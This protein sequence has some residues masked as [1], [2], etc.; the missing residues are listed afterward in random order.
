M[1]D[2]ID[3][4]PLDSSTPS[5]QE[6]GHLSVQEQLLQRNISDCEQLLQNSSEPIIII[7]PFGRILFYNKTAEHLWG[8]S[9]EEAIGSSITAFIQSD[10]EDKQKGFVAN[11]L[12]AVP[13]QTE[14]KEAEAVLKNG[15]Y[16]PM[17]I[18]MIE[19]QQDGKLVLAIFAKNI[20][21]EKQ[22]LHEKEEY[23][24]ELKQNLEQLEEVH[25]NYQSKIGD[26]QGQVNAINKSH[27]VITFDLNGYIESAN[28]IFLDLMEYKA[29]EIIGKHHRLFVTSEERES[30]A[31]QRFWEN[32]K[33]GQQQSGEFQRIT[34]SGKTVWIHGSYNPIFDAE[35]KPQK[36]VKYTQDISIIKTL[37]QHSQ[38]QL[39]EIR[40]T[41]EELRQNME[42]LSSMQEQLKARDIE[43]TGQLHAIDNSFACVEFDP[44]GYLLK[45]NTMFLDMFGYAIAEVQHKHHRTFVDS[46][47]AQTDDYKRFW[48]D[49]KEGRHKSGTF[50]RV[51]K[52]GQEVWISGSYTPVFNDKNEV[53]K[54]IKI[55]INVTQDKQRNNDFQSQL[56]AI[57]RTNVVVEFDLNGV[58]KKINPVFSELVGYLPYEIEGKHHSLLVDEQERYSDEYKQFWFNLRKGQP[59]T[60]E[61]KRIGKNGNVVW[62]NA[63]YTPI[64]DLNGTPYKI[65]KYGKDISAVKLLEQQN[66][67]Q[68]EELRATEEELR[69]NMEE[70]S[71]VQEQLKVRDIEMTGQMNAIDNSFAFIEF[72]IQ[73][74]ILHANSLFLDV[75]GYT[76][77]E[78][79]NRHHKV[80][81]DSVY[82]RSDEYQQFWA[83]L[84][85]AKHISGNFKRVN[86]K[87][88][89]IWVSGSYTPVMNDRGEVAKVIKIAIDITKERQQNND[90]QNQLSAINKSN[91]VV[92]FDLKGNVIS[93]NPI[94]TETFHY[95]AEAIIGKH[96]SLLVTERERYSEDYQQFW[97]KLRKGE[98]VTG[99]FERL[100]SE[101]KSVWLH[102]SY[103]P[104]L[105][106]NGMPYKIV[107][108]A[109]DISKQKH[110]EREV[111]EQ[112]EITRAGEEELRQNMEELQ[113]TQENLRQSLEEMFAVQEQLTSSQQEANA[114][115]KR[116]E[117][118]LEGCA[119]AVVTSNHL[120]DIEF[121]NKA[122][123]KLWGYTKEEM[124]GKNVRLLMP[125]EHAHNHDTY[126]HSYMQSGKAKVIGI[127]R[128]LE[129]VNKD[130]KK[131]PIH[132]TITEAKDGE[133][134]LFT[135]FLRNISEQVMLKAQQEEVEMMMRSNLE[136]LNVVQEQLQKSEAST[137]GQLAAINSAFGFVE[138][139]P[140]CKILSAN[141]R[142]LNMM[143]Y[144][145][146]EVVGGYH[147]IFIEKE[148]AE[149]QEYKNHWNELRNGNI[150]IGNFKRLTKTGK[151][152]WLNATYTPVTNDKGEVIKIIKLATDIT[153]FTVSLQA[154]SKF[155]NELK[156]GNFDVDFELDGAKAH[157]EV[158]KMIRDN[159]DLRNTLQGIVKEMNRV[160]NLAG[161]EGMLSERLKMDG[162]KGSWKG[163]VDSINLLLKS[164]SDPISEVNRLVLALSMGDLTQKIKADAKGD[165]ADMINALN[166]AFKNLNELLKNIEVGAKYVA[167]AS[168]D[169]FD[170]SESMK[171]NTTEVATAIQQMA[172]G[173]QEQAARTDESSRLVEAILKLSNVAT[174]KAAIITKV[175][176]T[177]STSA[178]EGLKIIKLVVNSMSEIAK[179]ANFTSNSIDAL[180]ERSEEISQ[181]L[182]VITDIASQTNLLALNA[183]IEAA[184]AGDAGRGFAVV[185][186]EIRKLAEDSRRSAV[187]IEKVIKDVQKDV[188]IA[189]KAIE[190]M[191]S[192]VENGNTATLQAQ[193]VF[194]DI[195]KYSTQ[196]LALSKDIL[197]AVEEQK[198]SISVVVKNIEK[199]VVVSEQTATGAQEVA[200]SSRQLNSSMSDVTNTS[201]ELSA[202]AQQLKDGV[203]RF[204]LN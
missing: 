130:G 68:L 170:K 51:A 67:H 121:F 155:L 171:I 131:I 103:S 203:G 88:E 127:G 82:A 177:G 174:A 83:D 113:S 110:L 75:F 195:N 15:G 47:Y 38:H 139:A 151:E 132:L 72:D 144:A 14:G 156:N 194:D 106:L 169:V 173:A 77:D 119:D 204:K 9:K 179:S 18:K 149:S 65:M 92:E 140:D 165:I 100:N 19:T 115:A 79:K 154:V 141:N 188:S 96:H 20:S 54:V 136:E 164:I 17:R 60:G 185:A 29:E 105:D 134:S 59:T 12:T 120:G 147:Q 152:V 168:E 71:T 128:E 40:A 201:K 28:Q 24:E 192:N 125:S 37:E 153:D 123:E 187:T 55:A 142:F 118:V 191:Q 84:K 13:Q 133:N 87:G 196:N 138:F 45:A 11:Y 114:M 99:E 184:R 50:K 39:E 3:E 111:Q 126:M 112:L 145:A 2:D 80:F 202:I 58:V 124:L 186:E 36:I 198:Q 33:N 98:F 56:E 108:Y 30:P 23:K 157:G 22:L 172:D 101:G 76:L 46:I 93:A 137:K 91:I 160:V 166:I 167:K 31:Y 162:I 193:E 26:F 200:S 34:K 178:D 64:L 94:F 150:Q 52:D 81:V 57:D 182:K 43:M 16:I 35:G 104:I 1:N 32:L 107:K 97:H 122:A 48:L 42:E 163:L 158:G 148:N 129:A 180:G 74:Y 183:A 143:G 90:I 10:W 53:I 86:K 181:T 41:E 6:Q 176:E 116:F 69:Q 5:H 95:E 85:A 73:G 175:A 63:T 190:K 159:I 161:E 135:A 102:G 70:L 4:F 109:K 66:H 44:Q 27:A 89:E 25:Q 61:F 189:N 21:R 78:I 117:S 8:Y 7:D 197:T 49:L 146:E 62:L 199:I